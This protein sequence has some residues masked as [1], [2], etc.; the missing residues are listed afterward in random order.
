LA[1]YFN[2][3][4]ELHKIEEKRNKDFEDNYEDGDWDTLKPEKEDEKPR[5]KLGFT[6]KLEEKIEKILEHYLNTGKI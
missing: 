1:L 3:Y 4:P 2:S 5:I 6:G